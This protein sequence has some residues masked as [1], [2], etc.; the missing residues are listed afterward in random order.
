[1]NPIK[2][3]MTGGV[4]AVLLLFTLRRWVFTLA[5][6]W[7]GPSNTA[8]APGPPPRPFQ[9]PVLL[10][11][12]VRNEAEAL[13][14][15]LSALDQLIYPAQK[16]TLVFI[17]DGSTDNSEILLRDWITARPNRHLLSFAQNAGKANALNAALA[18]FSTGDFVVIY[19]ADERPEPVALQRLMASFVNEQVGGV[20]GRRAVSNAL[21]GPAAGY[22][23]FEGLV[24][25]LVTM[26]AKDRLN[27]APAL[28]GANCA[29]RRTALMEV[30]GFKGDALLED[31]D[32]T[33]KLARAGWRTRFQPDAVSY[34]HVPQTVAGY[35][36]Q[37]TRWARGFN[38][39][40]KEQAVGVLSDAR[41]PLR[42]RLE[43]LI[44][45]VGYLDRLA[46]LAALGLA[47]AKSKSAALV[48]TVSLL[49]PMLQVATALK[50]AQA[51]AA[52][53]RQIIWLP[54][55]FVIDAAMA[56]TG[57]IN[58]VRQT[59]KIWEERR[60]RK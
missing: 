60:A 49:T 44:F 12:P 15:L 1:M 6:L 7:P 21:A 40:A 19:D 42:L 56:V 48:V 50:I 9:P 33:L 28:L 52:L 30:G 55:F 22:T 29:Y 16:L 38:E 59:P 46:L 23:T 2:K 32:L 47:I 10:L 43:L 8:D 58:T 54:L 17:N 31:S 5:A 11:V 37:H 24:H 3:A 26:R 25:Q 57:F 4:L 14:A 27:L 45:S 51:P 36:K 20:S 18:H 35:W 13:P 53:W 34:H 41:L 39:V